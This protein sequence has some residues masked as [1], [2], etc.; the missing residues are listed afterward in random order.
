M[1]LDP[2]TMRSHTH[3]G[4]PTD[5]GTLP[6]AGVS[7]LESFA[8]SKTMRLGVFSSAQNP[9]ASPC[10]PGGVLGERSSA[11]NTVRD[12]LLRYVAPFFHLGAKNA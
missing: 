9:A 10:P 5:C 12:D 4:S 1:K 2:F 8:F 11:T 7:D 6:L 3:L